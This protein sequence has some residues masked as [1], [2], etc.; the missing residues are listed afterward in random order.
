MELEAALL[1]ANLYNTVKGAYG[2]RVRK[3]KLWSNSTIVLEWIK[4][5]PNVLKTFVAQVSKIQGLTKNVRCQHVP[6][7]DNPADML[8]RGISSDRLI[9]EK[10]WWHGPHW[11][12][13]G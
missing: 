12:T 4:T 11:M 1:L 8:S 9:E 13:D 3:V 7:E 10:L 6:S 5:Q 2:D